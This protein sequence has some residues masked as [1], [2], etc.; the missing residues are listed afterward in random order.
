[1]FKTLNRCQ[2]TVARHENGHRT[3]RGVFIWSTS[4]PRGRDCILR[5]RHDRLSSHLSLV[6]NVCTLSTMDSITAS[7]SRLRDWISP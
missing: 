2:R 3:N 4:L 7:L 5:T 1:M 6:K